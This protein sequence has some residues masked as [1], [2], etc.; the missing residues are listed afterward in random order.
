MAIYVK[1][2]VPE[3]VQKE[4]LDMVAKAKKIRKGA[5]EVTKAVERGI[6]KLV[7]IAEDVKPE[8]IV[9]HLPPLCEEKNIP[10]AY[11]SSKQDLGKAAGIEV[12]SSSVAIIEPD[13][14]EELNKL[15]EKINALKE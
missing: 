1:F 10:Y 12:A 2:N 7:V 6:A 3:D 5:N 11:V 13:N 15:I 8:E 9:A 14:E 4:I